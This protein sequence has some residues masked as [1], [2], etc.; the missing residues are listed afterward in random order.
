MSHCASFML[1]HIIREAYYTAVKEDPEMHVKLT[2]SW[3]S[4]VGEQDVFCTSPLPHCLSLVCS[5]V[6][7]LQS[8]S[9]STRTMAV[10]TRPLRRSGAQRWVLV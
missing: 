2:G 6:M 4:V 3:E 8:I 5:A 7:H 9:W 1:M 10:T